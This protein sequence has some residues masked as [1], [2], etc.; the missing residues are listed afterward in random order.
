M[1]SIPNIEK[2]AC[3]KGEYVGYCHGAW[4]ISRSAVGGGTW[5]AYRANRSQ[6]RDGEPFSLQSGTLDGMSAKLDAEASIDR[7]LAGFTA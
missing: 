6:C 1:V 4:R 3:R 2:S 5:F 7:K